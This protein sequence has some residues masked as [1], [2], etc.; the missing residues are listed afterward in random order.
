MLFG[1]ASSNA[2]WGPPSQQGPYEMLAFFIEIRAISKMLDTS[3]A[4]RVKVRQL[5]LFDSNEAFRVDTYI[6]RLRIRQF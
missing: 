6:L 1:N 5:L 2:Y 4:L 3:E